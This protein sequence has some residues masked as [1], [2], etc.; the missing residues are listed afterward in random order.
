MPKLFQRKKNIGLPPGTITGNG[1]EVKDKIRISY[2]DYDA[3]HCQE[4]EM[5]KIEECFILKD[6]PTVTWINI[7][8]KDVDIIEKIDSC[9]GIHPLVL[10]DILNT[11]QRPK[12]E[13]HEDYLF[14]V[15]K[16]IH[17]DKSVNDIVAEQVSLVVGASYVIS[18]Q[19][20]A[21][22]GDVFDQI[23][24][25]IRE[26]R[27]RVRRMG[28]DYL[29]Y[30]LVDSIID[31]YFVVMEK[32]GYRIEEL[33]ERVLGDDNPNIPKE[34]HQL[35]TVI[36]YFRRQ[37]WPLREVLS[38][39]QR[40]ESKL[41]KKSTEAFL[42]DAYD[43]TIVVAETLEAF[44]DTLAGLHD[45]HLSNITNKMN[46]VMKV[47]TTLSTIFIPLTFIVG[48]YGMNFDVMPELHWEQG[49]HFCLIFMAVI[50]VVMLTIFKARKWL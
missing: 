32:V 47:L 24:S 15:L 12:F 14:I 37:I 28:A 46:E 45:I 13:D 39:L 18:F 31:N 9:Y 27:G 2:F 17:F 4:R 50:A 6:R 19:E 40:S 16:M 8:G 41:I 35:K 23:R 38:T 36:S 49:Y 26:N 5:E 21:E 10:E 3:N 34:I 25:R 20:T 22:E 7:E 42:R 29:A 44:K 48:I 1:T 30:C 11:E 33:E 43:H